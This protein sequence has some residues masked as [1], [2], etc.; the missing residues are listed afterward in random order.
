MHRRSREREREREGE[1][2]SMR[3]GRDRVKGKNGDTHVCD[4]I[5]IPNGGSQNCVLISFSLL[6]SMV[7]VEF[8][9]KCTS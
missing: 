2:G 6:Y 9:V 7:E 1:I 8:V 4:I 3:A 5:I